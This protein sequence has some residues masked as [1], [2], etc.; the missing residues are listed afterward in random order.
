MGIGPWRWGS[1]V[2]A[3]QEIRLRDE[4]ET[5]SKDR[6]KNKVKYKNG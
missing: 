4:Q 6:E 1:G 3:G 2:L 5:V